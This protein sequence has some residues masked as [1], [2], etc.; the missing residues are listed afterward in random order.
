MKVTRILYITSFV[1]TILVLYYNC[2]NSEQK[3]V[4]GDSSNPEHFKESDFVKR[5]LSNFKF[6]E[7]LRPKNQ[8][9]IKNID[10]IVDSIRFI[11]LDTSDSCLIGRIDKVC[12]MKNRIVLLDKSTGN[13]VLVF[14]NNGKFIN[15]YNK[16]GKG[17]NEFITLNDLAVANDSI[18]I[19][20]NEKIIL[21]SDR[22]LNEFKIIQLDSWAFDLA[23]DSINH[24]FVTTGSTPFGD[25]IYFNNS[26][27]SIGH[28]LLNHNFGNMF[29]THPF[30][31]LDGNILFY[32]PLLDSTYLVNN[33]TCIPIRHINRD[34]EKGYITYFEIDRTIILGY[35][36]YF[37]IKSKTTLLEFKIMKK[38][39]SPLYNLLYS[40]YYIS[41]IV[42]DYFISK[43]EPTKLLEIKNPVDK[44]IKYLQK[45][46]KI[47]SNPIIILTKFK[48]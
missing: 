42:G 35:Y 14:D 29:S 11:K 44:R 8:L 3:S 7:I 32:H 43:L 26:G 16:H 45:D 15:K 17:P 28:Y 10:E 23:V 19:L 18:Y 21:R 47:D 24:G 46:I 39:N 5:S 34:K 20:I 9:L 37:I 2:T 4:I 48:D 1:I 38:S 6:L 30:S 13:S 27:K 22:D 33:N 41:G 36:Q 40:N 25:V 31:F 12:L